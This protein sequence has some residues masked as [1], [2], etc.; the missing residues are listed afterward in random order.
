MISRAGGADRP[1]AR[2]VSSMYGP[3]I[4]GFIAFVLL[5]VFIGW[6]VDPSRKGDS[7]HDRH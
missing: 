5:A 1:G 3:L 4:G 7:G 6:A 2:Y